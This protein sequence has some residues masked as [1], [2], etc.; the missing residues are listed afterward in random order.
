[1]TGVI[2][3]DTNGNTLY[4]AEDVLPAIDPDHPPA[5]RVNESGEYLVVTVVPSDEDE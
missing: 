4:R 5:A 3:R 2:I 1:M